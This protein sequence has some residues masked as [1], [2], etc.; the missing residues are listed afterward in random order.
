MKTFNKIE[1]LPL[2][3]MYI[4]GLPCEEVRF[5]KESAK[6]LGVNLEVKLH[7]CKITV[8]IEEN[9]NKTS[10][11]AIKNKKYE[12]GNVVANCYYENILGKNW[13]NKINELA[14]YLYYTDQ[15]LK[16]KRKA[17]DN[18][19]YNIVTPVVL[20][21]LLFT[22]LLVLWSLYVGLTVSLLVSFGCYIVFRK[23]Y[24]SNITK[25]TVLND[26]LNQRIIRL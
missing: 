26:E 11:F 23:R 6:K 22:F 21:I 10:D 4:G 24:I 25:Y 9:G 3:T 19:I 2:Y 8:L 18:V 1:N 16:L 13:L 12:D 14:K 17:K 7:G 15:I 5:Y 20:N